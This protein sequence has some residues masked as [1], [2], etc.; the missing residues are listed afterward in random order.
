L[1]FLE[2]FVHGSHSI[3]DWE[4]NSLDRSA[5]SGALFPEGTAPAGPEPI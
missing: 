3:E 2:R 1:L 4:Q 5:R